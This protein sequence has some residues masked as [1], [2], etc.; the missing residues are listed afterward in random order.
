MAEDREPQASRPNRSTR[1][2]LLLGSIAAG[3]LILVA[4]CTPVPPAGDTTPP[5]I[6]TI[7]LDMASDGG[8]PH[9]DNNTNDTTPT[10]VG[11]TEANAAVRIVDG[12]TDVGSGVAN[13][14]GTYSVTVSELAPGAHDMRALAIDAAGNQSGPSSLLVVTID[15]TA[16]A[17]APSTPDMTLGT[18][19][20]A[21]GTDNV[22]NDDTPTFTGSAVAGLHVRLFS[23]STELGSATAAGGNWS[24]TSTVDMLDGVHS[25]T[26]TQTDAAGNA[27]PASGALSVRIDTVAPSVG[28]DEETDPSGTTPTLTG[29]AGTAL[30]DFTTVTVTIYAGTTTSGSVV[31]THTPTVSGTTWSAAASPALVVGTVY[32]AQATQGDVAGNT[33]NSPP[34]TFTA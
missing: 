22:T 32:T 17:T 1:R 14:A 30:G 2:R 24:I 16:P 7:D 28:L 29:P 4:A 23:G 34:D 10:F 3:A 15:T 21:S 31:Q 8:P 26:A 20:G 6:P 18:D 11:A 25:V 33:A 9:N 5:G 13:G 19:S 12:L 27:S